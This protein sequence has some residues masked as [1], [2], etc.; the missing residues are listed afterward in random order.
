MCALDKRPFKLVEDA[1]F[2]YVVQ[3]AVLIG[4]TFGAFNVND[5][6]PT[7]ATLS[8]NLQ[9]ISQQLKS[10]LI[11]TLEPLAGLALTC[12]HFKDSPSQIVYLGITVHWCDYNDSS[13]SVKSGLLGLVQVEDKK[14]KTTQKHLDNVLIEYKIYEKQIAIVTDNAMRSAFV[15]W[16]PNV[17]WL[18]CNAHNFNLF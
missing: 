14:D 4:S 16:K 10:N 12:D 5:E 1:G 18:S 7:A 6:F 11:S 3:A 2:Q 15:N 9:P 13:G 17:N 8:N